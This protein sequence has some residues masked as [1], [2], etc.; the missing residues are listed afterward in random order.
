MRR[1]LPIGIVSVSLGLAALIGAPAAVAGDNF[2]ISIAKSHT[3]N[4]T[5]GKNGTFT[6][7]LTNNSSTATGS[8]GF[9][10]TDTL[11]NGLTY[12]S[13]T[14]SNA[15]LTCNH[16]NQTVTC[17]GAP[18]IAANGNAS[19]TLTVAVANAARPSA[20]N[21]VTFS[22]ADQADRNPDNNTAT[23]DVTVKAAPTA[24]PTP[25]PT[26]AHV[27]PSATPSVAGNNANNLPLTGS[28][29]GLAAVVAL[30]MLGVGVAGYAATRTKRAH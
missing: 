21:S 11:P 1:Y 28:S 30:V 14:G 26:H 20:T 5:V 12:V 15:N 13:D 8:D 27:S 4:F 6:I 2:D 22:E 10:V 23:D 16:S 25:T 3:G 24:T 29:A 17:T 9:T 19:F 18:S 7:T